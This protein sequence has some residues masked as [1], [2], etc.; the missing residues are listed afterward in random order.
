MYAEPS[1]EVLAKVRAEKVDRRVFRVAL[2]KKK[3]E[4][5]KK[6]LEDVAFGDG[7]GADR[8]GDRADNGADDWAVGAVM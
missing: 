5:T 3:Y 6:Q 2:K 7:D 1:P 4:R 8:A